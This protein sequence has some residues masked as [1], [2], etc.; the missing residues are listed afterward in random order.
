[1]ESSQITILTTEEHGFFK[2]WKMGLVVSWKSC[3]HPLSFSLN[4]H[5]S[6][7]WLQKQHERM[8]QCPS[9]YRKED[10]LCLLLLS[11]GYWL[12]KIGWVG[13]SHRGLRERGLDAGQSRHVK[14]CTSL[15]RSSRGVDISPENHLWSCCEGEGN[16]CFFPFIAS[17]IPWKNPV[18]WALHHW[19]MVG[20]KIT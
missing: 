12:E 10:P 13:R 20:P 6:S 14:E 1:M 3:C 17:Q 7:R 16:K 8:T 15:L 2:D 4:P 18:H 5:K 11:G 19:P 9:S